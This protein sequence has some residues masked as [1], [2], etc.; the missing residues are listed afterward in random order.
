MST[1]ATR[2]RGGGPF[3]P[4]S[5]SSPRHVGLCPSDRSFLHTLKQSLHRAINAGRVGEAERFARLAAELCR[6]RGKG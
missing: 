4:T 6:D 2:N 1:M 3:L 5:K